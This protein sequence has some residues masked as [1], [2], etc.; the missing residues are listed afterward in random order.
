[1]DVRLRGRYI[2]PSIASTRRS[3]QMSGSSPPFGGEPR[4]QSVTVVGGGLMGSGIAEVV[5]RAGFD[6]YVIEP[7]DDRLELAW[8]RIGDSVGRAVSGGRLEDAAADELLSRLHFLTAIDDLPPC[9]LAIEA[10][11]EDA[12]VKRE[13]FRQ[14]DSKLPARALLASNT[15]SIPISDLAAVTDRP[16]RVLGLHFFSPAPVMRLVE[17]V[18]ALDT[19]P[20]T[21]AL[22]NDFVVALGKTAIPAK[23]RSGFIVNMLLVPYLMSAVRMYDE[24]FA[25]ADAIDTGMRLGCGHPMGPLALCDLV[26][27]DVL[28]AICNSLYDEF[29]QPGYSPPPLLKRM[30]ASG[31]LGRKSGQGFYQYDKVPAALPR[32]PARAAVHRFR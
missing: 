23:D 20:E 18:A 27:L 15:S 2:K 32:V 5:A 8:E 21:L 17:V 26:G 31:R 14:L 6:V 28:Y 4:I 10:V 24:G 19:T 13:V 16:G 29:G 11:V 12:T 25:T 22:A 1:M 7:D 9:E 30:V 3:E